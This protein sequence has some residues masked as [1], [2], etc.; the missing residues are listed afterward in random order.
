MN[1]VSLILNGKKFLII[2]GQNLESPAIV[3]HSAKPVHTAITQWLDL[4]VLEQTHKFY[5]PLY[6]PSISIYYFNLF[7]PFLIDFAYKKMTIIGSA[8]IL[9]QYHEIHYGTY[10]SHEIIF[11]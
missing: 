9:M 2:F 4:V 3:K 10:M 1:H 7:I 6:L 8:M 11:R 5:A